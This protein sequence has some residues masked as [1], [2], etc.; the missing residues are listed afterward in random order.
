MGILSFKQSAGITSSRQRLARKRKAA[1]FCGCP[2]T[3]VNEDGS[4]LVLLALSC[5][6]LRLMRFC[7]RL[8]PRCSVLV[9]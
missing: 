1:A 5:A 3:T 9:R 7:C 2:Y 6:M 4:Y 8:M